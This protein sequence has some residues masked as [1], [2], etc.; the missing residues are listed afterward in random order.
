MKVQVEEMTNQIK[1]INSKF[2]KEKTWK[3]DKLLL[4]YKGKIQDYDGLKG[5]RSAEELEKDE[6][7]QALKQEITQIYYTLMHLDKAYEL[8]IK[9]DDTNNIRQN[10]IAKVTENQ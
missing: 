7:V 1:F 4:L 9:R 6:S 3:K 5:K 10:L 8:K 2:Y